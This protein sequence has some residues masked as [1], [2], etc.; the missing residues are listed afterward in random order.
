MYTPG[1]LPKDA[2][3]W[4]VRELHAIAEAQTTAII[5]QQY[6]LTQNAP[7]KPREGDFVVAGNS[8]NPGYGSGP[9][10]YMGGQWVPMF[11]AS[12]GEAAVIACSD[13]TTALTTG[14][15]KRTF[16][17]PY[18]VAIDEVQ[19]SVNTAPVGSTLVVDININ[20]ASI[21]STK[22]TIDAG[23]KTSLTAA[24]APVLSATTGAKGDEVTIDIDQVGSTTAGTGLK[25]TLVWRRTA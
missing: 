22:L 2:Q 5:R 25:V 13:E 16:R 17:L 23:E 15:A 7:S 9:Y 4:M 18:A 3:P 14:T 10:V 19:A 8:W 12:F 20:G 6:D 1:A 11:G 24:T 21:L